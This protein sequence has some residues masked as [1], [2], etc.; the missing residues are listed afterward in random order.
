MPAKAGIKLI[1]WF[2]SFFKVNKNKKNYKNNLS[3]YKIKKAYLKKILYYVII[4]YLKNARKVI[5]FSTFLF[6]NSKE[7]KDEIFLSWFRTC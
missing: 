3:L 6:K 2:I 7:K 4:K 5:H 1:S